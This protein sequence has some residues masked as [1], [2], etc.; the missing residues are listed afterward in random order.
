MKPRRL[1]V[2]GLTAGLLGG[3]GAGLLMT[4]TTLASAQTDV[5]GTV[6]DPAA[7]DPSTTTTPPA[8]PA[9]ATSGS[10]PAPKADWAKAALD[11]LVAKGTIT[12]AQADEILAALQAARPAH[13]PGGK[14]GRGHGFGKLAAAA[15]ALNMTVDELRPALQGG[16]SLADIAKEKGIDVAKVVDAFVAQLNAHLDEHVASGKNTQA[17]AD[18][19]LADARSRIEAFVNGTAPAGGPGFGF[20]GPGG[21][22]H[23]GPGF[24][25]SGA[26]APSSSGSTSGTTTS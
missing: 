18:Q 4:G 2:F 19:M 23:R 11:Q 17:E 14:G 6:T 12:Q 20:G 8:A 21:R 26:P 16:K 10:A 13:G 25:G 5:T 1:A 3:G 24:G 15:S 22:G 9:P 7:S